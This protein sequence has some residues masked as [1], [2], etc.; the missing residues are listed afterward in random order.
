[1]PPAADAD[2]AFVRACIGTSGDSVDW[3]ALHWDDPLT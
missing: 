1:M 3:E 2:E